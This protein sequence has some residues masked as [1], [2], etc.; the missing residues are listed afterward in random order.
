MPLDQIPTMVSV[1]NNIL[2]QFYREYAPLLILD[3]IFDL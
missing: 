3:N 2:D 1:V